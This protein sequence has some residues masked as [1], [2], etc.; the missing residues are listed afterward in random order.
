MSTKQAWWLIHQDTLD[1]VRAALEKPFI[2]HDWHGIHPPSSCRGCQEDEQRRQAL[3]TLD[4]GCHV[5]EAIPTDY[6]DHEL[7]GEQL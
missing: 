5:T 3:H 7:S 1:A 2:G 4:S 6:Q